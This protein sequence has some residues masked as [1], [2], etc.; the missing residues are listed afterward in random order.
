MTHIF[1]IR[2]AHD[3]GTQYSSQFT[4]S[5]VRKASQ[6]FIVKIIERDNLDG[7]YIRSMLTQ[8][9]PKFVFYNG[10]GSPDSWWHK[11]RGQEIPLLTS[12]DSP[13]FK[14]KV[15]FARAC[16]SLSNMG[17][18]AIENNCK[19]YIGYD[20]EFSFPMTDGYASRPEHDPIAGPV[21]KASNIVAEKLLDGRTVEESI[22]ASHDYADAEF[23]KL[24]YRI[25]DDPFANAIL[26]FLVPNDVFLDFKGDPQATIC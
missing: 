26:T 3:A 12:N 7:N 11:S 2:T 16:D 14:D 22:K 13:L 5:L 19:A 20:K 21:F 1:V 23:N 6:T 24:I 17:E 9:K 4:N 25:E 10:H 8:H 15:I 18:K